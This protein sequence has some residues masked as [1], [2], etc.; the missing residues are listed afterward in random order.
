MSPTSLQTS[1]SQHVKV[2]ALRGTSR[3]GRPRDKK[4]P[5]QQ[6]ERGRRQRT[7]VRGHLPAGT[8]ATDRNRPQ[9]SAQWGRRNTTWAQGPCS[10]DGPLT[11]RST[12]VSDR[13]SGQRDRGPW[14]CWVKN[15]P[16]PC[17]HTPT[18]RGGHLAPWAGHSALRSQGTAL[19]LPRPMAC[20]RAPRQMEP[21]NRQERLARLYR[22]LSGRKWWRWAM[23]LFRCVVKFSLLDVA[24][25]YL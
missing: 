24:A 20:G 11:P 8:T 10:G 1:P 2:D 14:F 23:V 4:S 7:A 9:P 3:G 6:R 21:P 5:H 22:R 13:G 12:R 25:M 16:T 15:K 19:L 18:N 17:L